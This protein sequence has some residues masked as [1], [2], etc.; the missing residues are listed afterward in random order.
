MMEVGTNAKST[1]LYEQYARD[2]FDL[3]G[4][5]FENNNILD[6]FY[7]YNLFAN[8]TFSQSSLT[9]LFLP[10]FCSAATRGV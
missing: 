9:R 3:I 8:K 1:S 7:I 4:Q 2:F 10:A 5:T 6:L